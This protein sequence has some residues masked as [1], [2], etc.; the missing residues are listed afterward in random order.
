M[1]IGSPHTLTSDVGL[2]IDQQKNFSTLVVMIIGA[3][4]VG[5]AF[6]IL[7]WNKRLK[8]SVTNRTLELKKANDSLIESNRLLATAN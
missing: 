3:I 4:A 1:Y 7:S 5:I 2:L 6:I 8:T